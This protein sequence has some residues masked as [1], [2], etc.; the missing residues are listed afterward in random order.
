MTAGGAGRSR[1][2]AAVLL[3]LAV[4]VLFAWLTL[5]KVPF[6]ELG[7]HVLAASVPILS[8][9][10]VTKLVSM[11]FMTLRSV[12][13]FERLGRL[14]FGQLFRSIVIVVGGN[15]VIPLRAG[16]ALRIG[17]LV[18]TGGASVGACVGAVALERL[19]DSACLVALF[20][21]VTPLT[22][23]DLPAESS[24]Y[25]FAAMLV[26]G[27]VGAVTVA[28]RPARVLAWVGRGA[29]VAGPVVGGRLQRLAERLVEGLSS[30]RTARGA[31]LAVL[32]TL[33]YWLAMAAT[34]WVWLWAFH[35]HLPWHT[36]FLVL[37]FS[38]LGSFLPSSPGAVGTYHYFTLQAL[39][40]VG[41][42]RALATSVV[43][44]GHALA[45]FPIAVI[46][47]PFLVIE[48]IALARA[49]RDTVEPPPGPC[50]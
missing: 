42:E 49:R 35:L 32:A 24:L 26:L 27:L 25:V 30:L 39:L 41:V 10:L 15:A 2:V 6:G 13:V 11:L 23:L 9:A 21:V 36:A 7:Q 19:L 50:G 17:Y 44:V 5:R 43:V 18:R 3:G 16:E 40:L 29:E 4:S 14:S 46:S 33:G 38:A 31:A 22:M 47:L 34:A 48:V 28:R 8:L 12:V 45:F 20:A 1:K 37:F